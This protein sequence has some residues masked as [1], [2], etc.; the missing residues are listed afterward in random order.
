[1]LEQ[2]GAHFSQKLVLG[3]E[4]VIKGSPAYVRPVYD[5]LHRDLMIAF[6]CEKLVEGRE[7]R[8]SC[9]FLPSIHETL[10]LS[11]RTICSFCSITHNPGK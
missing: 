9:F 3:L 7:N 11:F 4:M 8:G 1:M 10:E 5:V 2:R 6:L